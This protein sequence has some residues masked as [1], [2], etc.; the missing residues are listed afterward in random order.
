M[1][2]KTFDP[3]LNLLASNLNCVV[4]SIKNEKLSYFGDIENEEEPCRNREE[5]SKS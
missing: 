2:V 5:I 1:S 4:L 3:A